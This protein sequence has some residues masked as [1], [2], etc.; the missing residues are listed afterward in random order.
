M[1][2]DMMYHIGLHTALLNILNPF[3]RLASEIA[4]VILSNRTQSSKRLLKAPMIWFCAVTLNTSP[5]VNRHS[6]LYSLEFNI[7]F[8][9][10]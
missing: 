1:K 7:F 2:H 5:S 4:T 3:R 8:C 9:P 10:L 6:K